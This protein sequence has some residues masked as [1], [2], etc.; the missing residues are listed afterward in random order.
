MEVNGINSIDKLFLY[1]K[2]SLGSKLVMPNND[3]LIWVIDENTSL[4]ISADKCKINLVAYKKVLVK[5]AKND[6]EYYKEDMSRFYK[7]VHN[8]IS[9][10]IKGEKKEPFYARKYCISLNNK[11]NKWFFI[12]S[13]II[14]AIILIVCYSILFK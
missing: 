2:D 12:I 13:I 3:N 9:K 8:I 7:D 4:F 10:L 6:V 5:L 14:I 1:Y 11:R